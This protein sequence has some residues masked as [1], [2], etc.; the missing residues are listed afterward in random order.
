MDNLAQLQQIA[1][2]FAAYCYPTYPPDGMARK[3][4]AGSVLQDLKTGD[5]RASLAAW[6][7]DRQITLP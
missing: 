1:I 5:I 4:L 3:A 2:D 6:L 7:K